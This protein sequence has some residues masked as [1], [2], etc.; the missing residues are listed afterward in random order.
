[1]LSKIMGM[2]FTEA[3]QMMVRAFEK[4]ADVLYGKPV[5]SD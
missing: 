4:R 5:T 3:V 2:V 1:M